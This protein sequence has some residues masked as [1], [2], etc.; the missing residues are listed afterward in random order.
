MARCSGYFVV[1]GQR[2]RWP[3]RGRVSISPGL[4]ACAIAALGLWLRLHDL[5]RKSFWLDEVLSA[6]AIRYESFGDLIGWVRNWPIPP[7]SYVITWALR[8]LGGGE[9][10]IRLPSAV[11]GAATVLAVYAVGRVLFRPRVGLLAALFMAV[12][13]F[14]VS[15]GQEAR[16]YAL[17]MLFT[18]LQM[19]AAYRAATR[20]QSADWARFAIFSLANL[21]THYL[22]IPATA[23]ACA[24]LGLVLLVDWRSGGGSGPALA[25]KGALTAAAIAAGYLPWLFDLIGFLRRP[26]LGLGGLPAK[27][28]VE[29]REVLALLKALDFSGFVLPLLLVGIATAASWSLSSRW[30]GAALM[31][32]WA[33]L[34]TVAFWLK[35]GGGLVAIQP[36]YLSFLFP[37]GVLLAALGVEGVALAADRA[38]CFV[39]D[40]SLWRTRPTRNASP[41]SR[42]RAS[43]WRRSLVVFAIYTAVVA[44]VTVQLPGLA[45]VYAHPKDDYRGVAAHL[46]AVSSPEAVVL[47]IG[48]HSEFIIWGLDFY[49]WR[50]RSPIAVFDAARL[51]DRVVRRL[52]ISRG[53]VWAAVFHGPPTEVPTAGLS[54]A[55]FTGIGLIRPNGS[56]VEPMRD[57]EALLTWARRLHPSLAGSADILHALST[58]LNLGP[59]MLPPAGTAIAPSTGRVRESW[60]LPA[61]AEIV[62]AVFRLLSGSRVDVTFETARIEPGSSYVISFR[63]R[64]PDRRGRPRVYVSTHH[65]DGD[66]LEIFPTG[67]G[68]PCALSVEWTYGAYGFTVPSEARSLVV[69]LRAEGGLAEF[70]DVELRPVIRGP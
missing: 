7:L 52:Q 43:S 1:S 21:Y 29:G 6:N 61:R 13:P 31:L 69:W 5:D 14:S 49:L 39:V 57:A 70:R 15:Y 10:A 68:Y 11:A 62:G 26:D 17:S 59:S 38:L 45:V 63:Y 48:H 23:A 47:A 19:L 32:L 44:A 3:R 40:A 18:T 51:D 30:R 24:Y 54:L 4:V 34:P 20:S 46:I 27:A 25:R 55:R 58:G 22:A 53:E 50:Q 65:E 16:P 42:D 2:M 28:H 67:A 35:A 41:P 8:G 9:M 60:T 64:T 66:W 36:R 12:L 56:S 37:A 33:G